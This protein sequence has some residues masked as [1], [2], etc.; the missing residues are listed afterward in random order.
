MHRRSGSKT[1]DILCR[2]KLDRRDAPTAI[3]DRLPAEIWEHI[4]SCCSTSDVFHLTLTCRR[5]NQLAHD[6]LYRSVRN[7][8]LT[9]LTNFLISSYFCDHNCLL[10]RTLSIRFEPQS[11]PLSSPFTRDEV[12][13]CA[14]R[15]GLRKT[16]RVRRILQNRMSLLDA[17][18]MK[19]KNLICLELHLPFV[20]CRNPAYL[21]GPY[22]FQL[23][24]FRASF[25]LTL[26]VIRFLESQSKTLTHFFFDFL[27]PGDFLFPSAAISNLV[28]GPLSQLTTLGWSGWPDMD[29]IR[30]LV[31]DSPCV[32][33]VVVNL[34]K[35]PPNEKTSINSFLDLGECSE[36]ITHV[37]AI[38]GRR[39]ACSA[40]LGPLSTRFEEVEFLDLYIHG[41][42]VKEILREIAMAIRQFKCLKHLAVR[43]DTSTVYP[44]DIMEV[45]RVC[46]ALVQT[47]GI[48]EIE[49]FAWWDT[50]SHRRFSRKEMDAGAYENL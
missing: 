39:D 38:I 48:V 46:F 43:A 9:G 7:L 14:K 26:P 3:T 36:R 6:H 4:I 18:L 44:C 21:A 25:Q 35:L 41:N 24:T 27:Y 23:N 11:T 10:V 1:L 16:L 8:T 17:V 20:D 37:Q 13:F 31:K 12:L 15:F 42:L 29:T 40:Y 19:F 30:S 45:V 49:H 28:K 33:T 50:M 34:K 5:L 32:H 2:L 47:L 22:S